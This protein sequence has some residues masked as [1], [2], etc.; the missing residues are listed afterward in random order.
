[1]DLA[2]CNWECRGT[3]SKIL[4]LQWVQWVQSRGEAVQEIQTTWA[5]LGLVELEL[6]QGLCF[7]MFTIVYLDLITKLLFN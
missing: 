6:C 2:T 4:G 1:M 7:N 3:H 5:Y